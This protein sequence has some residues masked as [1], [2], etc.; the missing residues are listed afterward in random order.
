M[1]S[2]LL[3]M[4]VVVTGALAGPVALKR[5]EGTARDGSPQCGIGRI[6]N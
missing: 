4:L 1:R 6:K 3:T 2:A 5:E